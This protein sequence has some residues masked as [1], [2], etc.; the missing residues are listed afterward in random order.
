MKKIITLAMVVLISVAA[1]SQNAKY[2]SS[3]ERFIKMMNDAKTADDFQNAANSF[4]RIANAE[5]K[6]WLPNYYE[7]YIYSRIAIMEKDNTKKDALLDKGLDYA[8]KAEKIAGEN[9]EI[10][11]VQSMLLG[12]KIGI[13]PQNRGQKLGMQSGMYMQTAMKLDPTNPRA[14]LMQGQSLMY[15]PEQYGGGKDKAMKSLEKSVEL[16]KTF[17]PSSSIMPTWGEVRASQ[18]LEECKNME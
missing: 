13:D 5:P 17:K 14:Y 10:K 11:V 18:A 1:Q 16:F 3:M 15:T 4:E 8:T 9:A 6:E 12:I 7:A 2:V